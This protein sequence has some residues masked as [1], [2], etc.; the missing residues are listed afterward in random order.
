MSWLSQGIKNAAESVGNW[1]EKDDKLDRKVAVNQM[2][3][4]AYD[5]IPQYIRD[6]EPKLD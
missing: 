5:R 4:R 1:W 2:V 3:S 6:A